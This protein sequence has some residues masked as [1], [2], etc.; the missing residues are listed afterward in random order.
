MSNVGNLKSRVFRA[1]D[2]RCPIF[3]L[4]SEVESLRA[5]AFELKATMFIMEKD[6]LFKW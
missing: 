3:D 5:R 2:H 1:S 6:K 4:G